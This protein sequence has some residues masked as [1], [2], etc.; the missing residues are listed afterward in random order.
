M[1]GH[2][3]TTVGMHT[4]VGSTHDPHGHGDEMYITDN[5]ADTWMQEV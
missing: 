3:H 1:D 2:I 5:I 4:Q